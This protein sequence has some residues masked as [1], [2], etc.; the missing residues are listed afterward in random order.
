MNYMLSALMSPCT[1]I[2]RSVNAR[3]AVAA[4]SAKRSA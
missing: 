4:W 2:E 3:T 1:S